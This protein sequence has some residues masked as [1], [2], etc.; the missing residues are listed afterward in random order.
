MPFVPVVGS[1]GISLVHVP[2]GKA[3]VT[4]FSA[5]KSEY[6]LKTSEQPQK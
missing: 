6:I 3:L 2:G 1:D 5:A 4:H